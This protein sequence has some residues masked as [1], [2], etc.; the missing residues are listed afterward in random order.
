MRGGGRASSGGLM[1]GGGAGDGEACFSREEGERL[2]GELQRMAEEGAENGGQQQ[3]REGAREREEKER[4]E[5]V[6][7]AVGYMDSQM[8]PFDL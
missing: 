4:S 7:Q 8:M 3:E 1:S 5:W 6:D 2:W